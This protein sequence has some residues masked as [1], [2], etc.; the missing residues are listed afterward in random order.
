[1]SATEY[2]KPIASVRGVMRTELVWPFAWRSVGAGGTFLGA[3][4]VARLLGAEQT[5]WFSLGQTTAT[6]AATVAVLGVDIAAMRGISAALARGSRDEA[7]G[8]VGAALS[9][10]IVSTLIVSVLGSLCA[11]YLDA[12]GA[13]PEHKGLYISIGL[14][15]AI[16]TALSGLFGEFL[17]AVRHTGWTAWFQSAC[18]PL[19]LIA[20]LAFCGPAL[21]A[22]RAL[23][24]YSACTGIAALVAGW[25]WRAKWAIPFRRAGVSKSVELLGTGVSMSLITVGMASNGWIEMLVLSHWNRGSDIALLYAAQRI[26]TL[27]ALPLT[28]INIVAAPRFAALHAVGMLPDLKRVVMKV[29]LGS[30]AVGVPLLLILSVGSGWILGLYGPAFLRAGPA[31][32]LLLAGQLVNLLCGPVIYVLMMCGRERIGLACVLVAFCVDAVC[33]TLWVP[34]WGLMGA[35]ASSATTTAVL[36]VLAAAFAYRLLFAKAKARVA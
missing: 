11:R 26:S 17:R 1:M 24:L 6:V 23:W 34:R 8:V 16:G 22:A 32:D 35:A 33:A 25:W 19:L 3:V 27:V 13:F 7:N 5:G 20:G 9:T 10:V 29:L 36:N 2:L 12:K 30:A 4:M 18:A 21:N 15:A 14:V 28:I 31:L